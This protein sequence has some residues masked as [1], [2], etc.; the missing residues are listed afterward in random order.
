MLHWPVVISISNIITNIH[1]PL[2]MSYELSQLLI[3]YTV[4]THP[5][6]YHYRM[7][8]TSL[9]SKILTSC[10]KQDMLPVGQILKVGRSMV[11]MVQ[12]ALTCVFRAVIYSLFRFILTYFFIWLIDWYIIITLNLQVSG[13]VHYNGYYI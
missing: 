6:Y 8:R 5:P 7:H 12:F 11:V 9:R 4:H 3:I 1:P 13:F 2:Y 10:P